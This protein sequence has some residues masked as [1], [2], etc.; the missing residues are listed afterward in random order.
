[1]SFCP[2]GVAMMSLPSTISQDDEREKFYAAIGRSL[3]LWQDVESRLGFIF[4]EAM[5]IGGSLAGNRAFYSIINS[6][7][8]LT[9]TNAALNGAGYSEVC[10]AAW[11]PISN[12]ATRRNKRRN[13]LAHFMLEFDAGRRAGYRYHLRPN[14]FDLNAA[15]KWGNKPPILNLCQI[16]AT[17]DAFETLA[18]DLIHFWRL[19]V[20]ERW[21]VARS[22]EFPPSEAHRSPEPQIEGGQSDTASEDP[23]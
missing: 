15:E 17:A 12:K 9:M 10:M 11:R 7:S 2:S 23:L 4:A 21:R 3:T 5:G 20:R 8:K 16:T 1:M 18:G 22:G 13:T 14:V 6:D 19:M